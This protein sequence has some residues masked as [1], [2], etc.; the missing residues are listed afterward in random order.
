MVLEIIPHE[1][2]L[3]FFMPHLEIQDII[4][5]CMVS[6]SG[7]KLGMNNEVWRNIY[8]KKKKKDF[9]LLENK[10]MKKYVYSLNSHAPSNITYEW[11][12]ENPIS[13]SL[14][15]HNKS[16][17]TFNIFHLQQFGPWK[18]NYEKGYGKILPN[19]KRVIRTYI[20]HRWLITPK[21][22]NNTNEVYQSK[23]LIIKNSDISPHPVE[24]VRKNGEI[25]VFENVINVS[26][27]ELYD[28]ETAKKVVGKS[29]PKNPRNFKNF[30]KMVF[31]SYI[32][33]VKKNLA[34]NH[35]I[36]KRD[37]R[38]LTTDKNKLEILQKK[39][40]ESEKKIQHEKNKMKKM[41]KFL[42]TAVNM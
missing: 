20:N 10:V 7:K 25:K 35:Q 38:T 9:Y 1:V 37:E 5:L 4:S 30:R 29:L 3:C 40:E 17:V 8:I 23:G 2:L 33:K 22:E 26:V 11:G 14:M 28:S 36:I 32:P 18:R 24:F 16:D 39:I 34:T 27:G 31:K 41:K 15:I 19:D 12:P 6:K 13:V 42:D 21:K